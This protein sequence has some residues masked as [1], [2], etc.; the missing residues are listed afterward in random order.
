MTNLRCQNQ[1]GFETH[2]S[3]VARDAAFETPLDFLKMDSQ[4]NEQWLKEA[5]D[6]LLWWIGKEMLRLRFF[7]LGHFTVIAKSW[8]RTTTS[9][10]TTLKVND[11]FWA[12]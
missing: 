9:N 6:L 4:S 5:N 7:Y 8:P 10:L 11:H 12:I 2:K 3:L 1:P